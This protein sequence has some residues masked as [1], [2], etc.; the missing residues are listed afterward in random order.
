MRTSR[1]SKSSKRLL[2]ISC[3]IWPVGIVWC[4][5]DVYY[6]RPVFKQNEY[7]AILDFAKSESLPIPKRHVQ[8]NQLKPNVVLMMHVSH[9][10][11]EGV[12]TEQSE[13]R[14]AN[15]PREDAI[16]FSLDELSARINYLLLIA[17]GLL[18]LL[19]KPVIEPEDGDEK[20][21]FSCSDFLILCN[22][23]M[24]AVT[25][26][27]FGICALHYIPTAGLET[28]VSLSGEIAVAAKYQILA[29]F[30]CFGL[31]AVR[32]AR[33]AYSRIHLDTRVIQ[34]V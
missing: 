19:I 18:G 24:S 27:Y 25:S 28:Y 31:V 29:L 4:T 6:Y 7:D 5:L 2:W 3:V 16:K 10:E 34:E 14:I 8:I 22:V 11:I 26:M 32:V 30:L 17:A 13:L 21:Q 12:C 15:W 23:V 33:I 1:L 9:D 20:E